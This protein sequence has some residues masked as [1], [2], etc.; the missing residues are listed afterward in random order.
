MKPADLSTSLEAARRLAVT[1]QRLAGKTPT[2]GTQEDLVT[3]VRDLAFVQWDPIS[4][5]CPSHLISFWSRVGDFSVQDLE[6]LF[7]HQKKLF[8]TSTPIAVIAPTEDYPLHYALMRR[9]PDS[10][11]DSWG[12]Q[13][14]RARRFLDSHK[15]LRKSV[16]HQLEKGPRILSQFDGYVRTKRNAD[17]WTTGSEVSLML[18]Y[19]QM[20]GDVMVVG[21]EGNQNVWGLSREFLPAWAERG[22]LTEE[23]V[24][25]AATQKAIRALGTAAAREINYYFVRGRYR[26]LKATLRQLQADGIIHPIRVGGVRGKEPRYI[27]DEDLPLLDSITAGE[28][29]PRMSLLAPFDNLICGRDRTSRLF[30]FDY[31]HE[32]FVPKAKR[33]FGTYV[34]PILWGERL[35]GR[36][37]PRMDRTEERLTIN[38]VHAEPGAPTGQDVASQI[39]DTLTRFATFLGAKEVAY[40]ARVPAAWKRSLR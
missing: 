24:D 11:S 2:K 10:L 21:H 26:N 8:L 23:D 38:S 5:V 34:L 39:G 35:I 31:V 16:L 20:T 17:G 6:D 19:L 32:Q 25:R 4:I 1:K 33:K 30:G 18:S 12:A 37:D 22:Q 14:E 13:R 40:S 9:Y 27:H 36:I 15:E 29:E 3:V 28:W 7:W